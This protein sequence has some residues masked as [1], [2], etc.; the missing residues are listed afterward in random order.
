VANVRYRV[1]RS[2]ALGGLGEVFVAIDEELGREVALKEIQDRH[3]DNAESRAR[4]LLEAEVTGGLEHPGI[5]PVYGLGSYADGRPYYAMRLIRGSSLQ[6]AIHRFHEADRPSRNPHERGLELRQL[7]GRFVGVCNAIAYAHSRGVLHRDIK[8]GNVMLGQFGETLV[9]DWGLAKQLTGGGCEPPVDCLQQGA[10]TPRPPEQTQAGA[11]LGTPAFMSPEQAAG[12]LDELGPAS[13]VYSLGATLYC[14]LTNHAP[15]EGDDVAGILERV[16]RGDFRPARQVEPNVPAALEA[17]CGKAMALRPQDRYASAQDLAAEVEKW[18]AD[19]PV[20]AFRE[21][22]WARTAR[23]RRRHQTV[24]AVGVALCLTALAAM[25][26]GY[27]LLAREQVRTRQAEGERIRAQVEALLEANPQA[28]PHLLDALEPFR[29]QATP[30]LRRHLEG[31]G[32]ADRKRLRARL[33]LLREHPEQLP[34]LRERL[35]DPGLDP[36][37]MLLLCEIL[38]PYRREVSAELWAQAGR[39][40]VGPSRRFRCLVALARL[41]RDNPRWPAFADQV[42]EP[43]LGSDPLHVGLWTEALAPVREVL[44]GAL[45]RVFRDPVRVGERRAAA[46]VLQEYAANNPELLVDLLAD[47]DEH[48]FALLLPRL[49]ANRDRAVAGLRRELT[50]MLEPAWPADRPASAERP[51]AAAVREVESAAGLVTD[52]FALCQ[53][54]PLSRVA[55]L[56]EAL[57]R[58]GY[59]PTRFRPFFAGSEVRCA[60]V[61]V[62][63]GR[64]WK[65]AVAVTAEEVRRLDEQHQRAGFLPVD[66]AGYSDPAE[67]YVA[68]WVRTT[69]PSD[70]AQLVVGV[71]EG[72]RGRAGQALRAE[73]LLPRTCQIF[74]LKEGVTQYSAVWGRAS[75]AFDYTELRSAERSQYERDLPLD[76]LLI[77]LCLSPA[78]TESRYTALWHHGGKR[79]AAEVHGLD[80]AAH[81]V[82]CRELARQGYRPEVVTVVLSGGKTEAAS[83]WHRPVVPEEAREALARRQAN[84]AA[85]LLLLGE[86]DP[87]WPLLRHGPD[88]RRRTYLIHALAPLGVEAHMVVQRLE[89][90]QEESAR[91][92]LILS[93]S[94]FRPE[95]V[96]AAMRERLVA[97]LLGWYRNDLDPGVHGVCGWLLGRVPGWGAEDAV[98]GVDASL[99]G[100]APGERRWCVNRQGQTLVIVAGPVEFMMGSPNHAPQRRSDE[101]WHRQRIG[102]SFALAT[103][104][105]TA[106]QFERF[107]QANPQVRHTHP[108]ETA[109][110]PDSPAMALNWYEAAQY[111][112]WL[113]EQEEIPE[114]QMC[115]PTVAEIEK[116][117][118][119]KL[120][121]RLPANALSRTGYRLPTEAEW[122]YACRA[123]AET[124]RFFGHAE[125]ML[126]PYAWYAPN[127]QDHTWP[128]GLK[129]PNDLGLF[130]MHG[131][132]WQWCHNEYLPYATGVAGPAE[133]EAGRDEVLGDGSRSLRGGTFF[134]HG[135]SLRSAYRLYDRPTYAFLTFGLRVA[136]THRQRP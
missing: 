100:K 115:Y 36:E 89:N 68:L 25:T 24:V 9:V 97:R 58:A 46:G 124:T 42:V 6:D 80:P 75:S 76:R 111:C 66:V 8:P 5:V 54:L 61:W 4:F 105:V 3:A 107:L 26:V 92:A 30:H 31:D 82:R 121:L 47:A 112:R 85:A 65:A 62:R 119:G 43:L 34:Y 49:Q 15:F 134:L 28:V 53:S 113:S 132:V 129:M 23:W 108:W 67:R 16:L 118:D 86:P 59:R 88:P 37:E 17:V 126:G 90:E 63:D 116:C 18:L 78:G 1:V 72:E 106:G 96:P 21:S 69:E 10:R 81:L 135:T 101:V 44:V 93:L 19:E 22:W 51:T 125:A 64:P 95:Q 33:A 7:L 32:P 60:A 109:L 55:G 48:Q 84:A 35:V 110:T 103:T 13:D 56:S 71:A 123:G 79:T 77:D 83:V 102:R 131:N 136:R 98:R 29:D 87:V 114:D 127:S 128:V 45:S 70:R 11:V 74:P 41:D 99:A 133:D 117:K 14:L 39:S 38:A 20:A 52:H 40:G 94:L 91:R 27:L 2:H 57:G 130:D 122:E 73:G 12:R 104:T 120:P 50:R